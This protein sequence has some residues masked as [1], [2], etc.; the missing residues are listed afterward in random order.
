M[1]N[2]LGTVAAL[3]LLCCSGCDQTNSA[4]SIWGNSASYIKSTGYEF[5]Y[6]GAGY[7]N[8]PDIIIFCRTKVGDKE[9]P[10]FKYQFSS[11]NGTSYQVIINGTVVNPPKGTFVFYVNDREGKS[12]EI[13]IERSAAL[14]ILKADHEEYIKFWDDHV[15]PM[16]AN[17]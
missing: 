14:R 15:A 3:W 13:K 2:A 4:V 1:N 8:V 6:G 5:N 17:P 11:S 16:L 7:E 10:T 9:T 12:K